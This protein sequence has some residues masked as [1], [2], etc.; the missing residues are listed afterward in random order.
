[1]SKQELLTKINL[2][3]KKVL[4]ENDLFTDNI[5]TSYLKKID[6]V[7]KKGL[8]YYLDPKNIKKSNTESIFFRKDNFN[9]ELNFEA[10]MVVNQ[11]EENKISFHTLAKLSDIKLERNIK[12]YTISDNPK[13]VADEVRIKLYPKFDKYH[14]KF[15]ENLISKFAE[16]NILVF[17]HIDHPSKKVK[18]N[19]N[20]FYLSPDVIVLKR[21]QKS[22]NREI[23]TLIHEL[24]HYLLNKEEIDDNIDNENLF[25]ND[26]SSIERWCNDFAYYFLISDYSQTI[27]SLETAKSENDYHR[28]ILRRISENTHLSTISLYT[29]LLL[30]NKISPTNYNSV[31]N[32]IFKSIREKEDIEK[33]KLELEKKK[34]LEEGRKQ[35]IPPAKPILSPLY[36]KT[37]QNALNIGLIN[38]Y[39]FCTKLKINPL[40]IEKYLV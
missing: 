28:D 4:S 3:R 31:K 36:L 23:F 2:G 6:G 40:K 11:F 14:K 10:K 29:R 24:G 16:N 19:I 17:E 21:N 34:A 35:I 9:A 22:F 26:L 38:E 15:L 37:L 30:N 12:V 8:P 1:M 7:F 39:D 13:N 20:G 18:A 33:R 25:G 32:Q 5:K 27:D